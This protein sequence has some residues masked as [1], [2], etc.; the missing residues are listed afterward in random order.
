MQSDNI[1]TQPMR[2]RTLDLVDARATRA[3]G[4]ALATHLRAG[5]TLALRGGLGAGKT[6]LARGIIQALTD[7]A[8][9]VPSPT[10]TLV[11]IYDTPKGDLWHGDMYRLDAACDCE[12]LGLPDAFEDAIC[13][14]EWP[15]KLGDY[16]PDDAVNIKVSFEGDH[17]TVTLSGARDWITALR[18]S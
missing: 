3:L 14:I 10:Y 7:E 1:V 4:A 13:I 11:Q 18:V 8:Q 15:D 16:L 5:D 9:E 12:E 6:T 17:R 2:V